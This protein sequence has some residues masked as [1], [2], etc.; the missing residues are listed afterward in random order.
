VVSWEGGGLLICFYKLF[1]IGVTGDEV[2]MR[3]EGDRIDCRGCARDGI[4]SHTA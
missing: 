4:F 3:E 1:G 2:S